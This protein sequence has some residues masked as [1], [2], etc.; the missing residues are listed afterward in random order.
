[1]KNQWYISQGGI[2]SG[3]THLFQE[4]VR[5]ARLNNI[6][7]YG[8]YQPL[9]MKDGHRYGYDVLMFANNQE[10]TLP[11]VRPINKITPEGMIWTFKEETILKTIEFFN[12]CEIQQ[13]PSI[14]LFDEFGRIEAKGNGQWPSIKALLFRLNQKQVPSN[15]VVSIRKQVKRKLNDSMKLIGYGNEKSIIKLPANEKKRQQFI[16]SLITDTLK[17]YN[18]NTD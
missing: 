3:K 17:L 16:Q 1:M 11:F 13:K 9:L 4:I 18:H 15:I 6:P 14:V 12:K 10:Q 7:Y 2:G 8:F 5:A